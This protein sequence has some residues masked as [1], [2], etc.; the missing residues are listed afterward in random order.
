MLGP[1]LRDVIAMGDAV[2]RLH[3]YDAAGPQR[4]VHALGDRDAPVAEHLHQLLVV[5]LGVAGIRRD[6]EAGPVLLDPGR[7]LVEFAVDGIEQEHAA[8]PVGN[9]ADLE[10]PGGRQ[11]AA[12]IADDYD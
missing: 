4:P 2:G 5:P 6:E 12:A 9:A 7:K 1:G 10:T 8:D 11:E 3:E